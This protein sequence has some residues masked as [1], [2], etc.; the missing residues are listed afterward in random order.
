MFNFNPAYESNQTSQRRADQIA[1]ASL[2]RIRTCVAI[3]S[4]KVSRNVIIASYVIIKRRPYSYALLFLVRA[5]GRGQI[6]LSL[7]VCLS[8]TPRT[9]CPFRLQ[10]FV[11]VKESQFDDIV[12]LSRVLCQSLLKDQVRQ[13]SICF[14]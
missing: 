7:T 8:K 10:F 11:L 3:K 13:L 1:N 4:R 12:A 5:S 9:L 14:N 6:H 2:R